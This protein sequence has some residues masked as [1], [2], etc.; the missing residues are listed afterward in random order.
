VEV[1][2]GEPVEPV[3][4]AVAEGSPEQVSAARHDGAE[5]VKLRAPAPAAPRGR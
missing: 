1:E 3:V 2:D 4:V 5:S